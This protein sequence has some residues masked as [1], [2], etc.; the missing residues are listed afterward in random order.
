M[1]RYVALEGIDGAGKTHAQAV[2]AAR[3]ESAGHEVVCVR[4]PGETL[5]GRE[6]RRLV[7]FRDGLD[8]WTEALLFAADRAQLMADVI[9]PALERGAWVVSD[10]SV[11]SSLAYQ[12]AGRQLGVDLIRR[13]NEPGLKGV[14][15]GLVILLR[16]GVEAGVN[17]QARADRKGIGE[18]ISLVHGEQ[19][20]FEQMSMP[21]IATDRIGLSGP[22]F[23]TAVG[24]A[25]DDLARREPERFAVIDAE[26]PLE[27]VTEAVLAA[28]EVAL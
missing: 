12:G 7:L 3:I 20:M 26:R 18:D 2:I 25:F 11:Y 9:G 17:R 15:P 6:L 10:R 24:E 1:N 8:A 23:L 14:W 28:L 21:L 27:E 16:V 13:I 4:E 5:L 19:L 22:R